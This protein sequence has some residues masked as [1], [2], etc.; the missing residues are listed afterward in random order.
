M[1]ERLKRGLLKTVTD[2]S[3]MERAQ[4][5]LKSRHVS[6]EQKNEVLRMMH[7]GAFAPKVDQIVDEKVAK[8]IDR[9]HDKEVRRAIQD[10]RV[11][12]PS[13]VKDPW[14]QKRQKR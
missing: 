2:N 13:K 7:K 14:L 4:E 5:V 3:Q 10:G 8:E 12:D 1:P 11:A 6:P 9:Y